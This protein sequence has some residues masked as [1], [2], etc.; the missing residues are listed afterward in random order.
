MCKVKFVFIFRYVSVHSRNPAS[1]TGVVTDAK[2]IF[3]HDIFA[4]EIFDSL[5]K[6]D[7]CY[8]FVELFVRWLVST[9][10]YY[11]ML[12]KYSIFICY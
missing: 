4:I 5:S 9:V 1:V 11:F 8:R 7:T 10:L 6:M 12:F 2:E 3:D